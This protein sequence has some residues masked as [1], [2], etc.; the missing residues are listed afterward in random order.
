ML[1]HQLMA[2]LFET[3]VLPQSMAAFL[4]DEG[5]WCDGIGN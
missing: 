3:R 4:R 5:W 2:E 1:Q